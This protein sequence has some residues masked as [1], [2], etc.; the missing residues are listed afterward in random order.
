MR[1]TARTLLAALMLI[2]VAGVMPS[3]D[4]AAIQGKETTLPATERTVK[5]EY[6]RAP[7]NAK[8]PTILMLHGGQGWG[9][10]EGRIENFRQYGSELAA[11]GFDA[12][13]VYYYSDQDA[14]DRAANAP[15]LSIKRFPAWA[16]L[17]SDLTAD[18]KKLPDSNGKV[19]LVGFSNGGNLSAHATPL[20]PNIDAAVVH[21]AG[22]SRVPGFEAKRF[23]PLLIM[24]GE[25]DRRQGI[26]L[27]RKLY[28]VAKALGGEVEFV[29]Y[30]N[31][32]HGFAQN[33]GTFP[34]DDAFKRTLAFM[35]KHL[36]NGD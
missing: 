14:K 26:E 4:A 35:E 10:A 1:R 7:G 18:V 22:V 25:A 20:D 19:G 16:K 30:P 33:F 8:R 11:H 5:V 6:F 3:A 21:Y 15:G 17:V 23:P 28:D 13:M 32:D 31:T 2:G 36:K 34:A 24:H 9:G 27:G 12:Y 29:S